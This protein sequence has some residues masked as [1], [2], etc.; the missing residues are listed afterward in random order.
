MKYLRVISSI[1]TVI[2]G[3]RMRKR[4]VTLICG[5]C[6][7]MFIV[8]FINLWELQ[9]EGNMDFNNKISYCS[10]VHGCSNIAM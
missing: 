10:V 8:A 7:C 3:N 1:P 2:T 9:E 6:L 4:H 5:F